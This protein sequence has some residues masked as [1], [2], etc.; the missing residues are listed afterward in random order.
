MRAGPPG[1]SLAD[2]TW[3]IRCH[4]T[5]LHG[6]RM[7]LVSR[8]AGF[9]QTGTGR[10]GNLQAARHLGCCQT[11]VSDARS[12]GRQA[13][14]FMRAGGKETYVSQPR[15]AISSTW[16]SRSAG[17]SYTRNAPARESASS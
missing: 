10:P 6:A 13:I 11:L 16:L 15:A 12:V 1:L 3:L 9:P 2:C 17:S 14:Q 5:L 8:A 7:L 4:E